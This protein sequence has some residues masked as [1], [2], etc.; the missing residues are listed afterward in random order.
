MVYFTQTPGNQCLFRDPGNKQEGIL[1]YVIREKGKEMPKKYN[2]DK[3]HKAELLSALPDFARGYIRHFSHDAQDRS[4]Y[5]Y[6][7]DLITF[8]EFLIRSNPVFKD[9]KT[10]DFT[11]AEMEAL[12]PMDFDEYLADLKDDGNQTS[13][14]RRKLAPIHGMYAY[15]QSRNMITA[16]PSANVKVKD[17]FLDNEIVYLTDEETASLLAYI[18]NRAILPGERVN[19][20]EKERV[21]DYAIAALLLGT[22][23]RVSELTNIDL[24]DIDFSTNRVNILRKGGATKHVYM[25]DTVAMAILDY[26]E[27]REFIEPADE[28]AKQAL[29]LSSQR[30]RITARTIENL[31]CR[32]AKAVVPYKHITPHKLRS[33]FATSVLHKTGNIAVVSAA[34]NH[35]QLSTTQRYYSK[36][37]DE[38]LKEAAKNSPI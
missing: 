19:Q 30:R 6:T 5:A 36:V 37:L 31:I 7:Y 28:D 15:M 4:V 10:S 34:L 33:S 2:S 23:M 9:R 13:A 17:K 25:S 26:I 1:P 16:D 27:Q 21:R 38:D 20:K 11:A 32:Y 24:N 14:L 12:T 22:G 29:F 35:K 8:F 3:E 18:K